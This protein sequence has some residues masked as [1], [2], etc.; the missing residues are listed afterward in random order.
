M[1]P[2]VDLTTSQLDAGSAKWEIRETRKVAEALL[3]G[4]PIE[5][6]RSYRLLAAV[7]GTL[8]G[9]FV[10]G[11][12]SLFHSSG[13]WEMYPEECCSLQFNCLSFR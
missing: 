2:L 8:E 9:S 10:E 11:V 3:A 7:M 5:N 6:I 1:Q 4:R 12:R 13:S